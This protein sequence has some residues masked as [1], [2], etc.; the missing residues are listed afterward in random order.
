MKRVR[1]NSPQQGKW[2]RRAG[3][4]KDDIRIHSGNRKKWG[5][6]AINIMKNNKVSGPSEV[7]IKMCK[8][9][10]ELGIDG[11]KEY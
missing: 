1:W 2:S 9:L 11:S 3:N 7:C 8:E 5:W 6:G 4:Y 10:G